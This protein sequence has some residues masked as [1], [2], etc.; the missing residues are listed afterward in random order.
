MKPGSE[1]WEN[2]KIEILEKFAHGEIIAHEWLRDRFSFKELDITNFANTPDFVR[3]LDLQRFAYMSLVDTLRWELLDEGKVFFKNIRGDGYTL[4]PPKDQVNYAY[5][6]AVE[7][8][9]KEIREADLIMSNVLHV[10]FE[11]Q[12]LDNNLKARF[13]MLK[14]MLTSLKK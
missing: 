9:K 3:A 14:Q 13:S 2:F 10:D 6:K 7:S 1:S 11:Q 12:S 5:D 4:M 8:F